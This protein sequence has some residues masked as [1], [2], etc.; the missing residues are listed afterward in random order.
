MVQV[1]RQGGLF[2]TENNKHKSSV[3][4]SL[5]FRQELVRV[6]LRCRKGGSFTIFYT[7]QD[8][9]SRVEELVNQRTQRQ[10][11]ESIKGQVYFCQNSG[12]TLEH[13]APHNVKILLR[14]FL[15]QERIRGLENNGTSGSYLTGIGG[16]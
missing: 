12:K 13:R 8:Y 6:D 10:G 3:V 11:V 1:T 7:S 5:Q 14:A 16:Q 4:R 15:S 2:S 9:V